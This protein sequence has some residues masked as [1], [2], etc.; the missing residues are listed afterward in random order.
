MSRF[1]ASFLD[2][3]G[4]AAAFQQSTAVGIGDMDGDGVAD[5]MFTDSGSAGTLGWMRGLGGVTFAAAQTKSVANLGSDLAIV[6]VDGDDL[7]DVVTARVRGVPAVLVFHGRA[8]G[9]F[10]DPIELPLSLSSVSTL[11]AN[12]D[13]NGDGVADIVVS[14]STSGSIVVYPSTP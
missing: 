9:T 2:S 5:I 7:A 3:G 4:S 11:H 6:D 12:A 13:Y 10:G 1:S 8:D 14:Q